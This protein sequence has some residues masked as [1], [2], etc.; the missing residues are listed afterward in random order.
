MLRTKSLTGFIFAGIFTAATIGYLAPLQA[1]PSGPM[2]AESMAAM[3]N[4]MPA[5]PI[6]MTGIWSITWD[7][8]GAPKSA[9]LA[10]TSSGTTVWGS[11]VASPLEDGSMCGPVGSPTNNRHFGGTIYTSARGSVLSMLEVCMP[12][13]YLAPMAGHFVGPGVVVGT[14]TDVDGNSGHF[15][16]QKQ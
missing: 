2:N 8:N 3:R 15:K 10:L 6:N 9:H 16:M 7:V 11:Y 5:G 12:V 4:A 13:N 14:W 1:A